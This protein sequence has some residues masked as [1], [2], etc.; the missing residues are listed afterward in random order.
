M[1]VKA[2]L[3]TARYYNTLEN[4]TATIMQTSC[5]VKLSLQAVNHLPHN[6]GYATLSS[7]LT[8]DGLLG[9]IGPANSVHFS[10]NLTARSLRYTPQKRETPSIKSKL[11]RTWAYLLSAV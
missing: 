1:Y 5:P 10:R 8:D 4:K 11:F 2:Y 3:L 7:L 6:I 9:I